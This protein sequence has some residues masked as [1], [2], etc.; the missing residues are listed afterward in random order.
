MKPIKLTFYL[1]ILISILTGLAGCATLNKDECQYADWYTIGF[2]DGTKGHEAGQINKHRQA[3]AEY[4]IKPDIHAYNKGR[5]TGL[6][7]YCR[8]AIGYQ[9]GVNGNS[10]NSVCP[11]N[12]E[13]DF[14]DAYQYGKKIYSLNSRRISIQKR[15]KKTHVNLIK[16]HKKIKHKEDRLISDK[17]SRSQRIK[18]L[19]EIKSLAEEKGRIEAT[20]LSL[21]EKEHKLDH[22]ISRMVKNSPY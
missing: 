9:K 20:T 1:F 2:S 14:L 13:H 17:T 8:P 12:L 19:D 16:I 5:Q 6:L 15:L 22:R 21:E 10:Y 4:G 7:E 11:A 3:C 18:L